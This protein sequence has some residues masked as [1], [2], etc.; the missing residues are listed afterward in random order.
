MQGFLVEIF[1]LSAGKLG[2]EIGW[3]FEKEGLFQGFPPEICILII[4]AQ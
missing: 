1:R 4:L 3:P 2:M